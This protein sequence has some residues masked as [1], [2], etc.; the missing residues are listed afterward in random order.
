MLS[1]PDVPEANQFAPTVN[2]VPIHQL[3]EDLLLPILEVDPGAESEGSTKTITETISDTSVIPRRFPGELFMISCYSA[4]LDGETNSQRVAHEGR[5]SDRTRRRTKADATIAAV[6]AGG[7]V[8]DQHG[9]RHVVHNR[10]EEFHQ[11]DSIDVQPTPIANLAMA[12][13]E[14]TRIQQTSKITKATAML[15]AAMLQVN[16]VRENQAPSFSTA[17]NRLRC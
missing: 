6:A 4:A 9:G 13:N 16:E 2:I 7:G 3:G 1:E 5:N 12:L 15:K 8:A 17:S 14:L 11:V 10:I